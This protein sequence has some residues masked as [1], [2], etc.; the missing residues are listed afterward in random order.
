MAYQAEILADSISE[1]GDRLTTFEVTFPRLILAEFN[2]PRMFSR[3]SAS[4]RAIPVEK[5][6]I[7]V[8]DE[9]FIPAYWGVNQPGMQAGAELGPE[10]Q[11][12]ATGDWLL[13][14]DYAVLGAV[15]LIG[16][17]EKLK[18]ETLRERID[19]IQERLHYPGKALKTPLHK[20]I[21]NREL[22]PYMWHTDIITATELSNF[23]ALRANPQA[24]PAFQPIAYM[25]KDLYET[26]EPTL[27]HE[28]EWH[29]PLVHV[30]ERHLSLDTLKKVSTGRCARVSYL[31]HDTGV[32]DVAKDVGLHD[33][34]RHNGHMSPFEHPARPMTAEEREKYMVWV[35]D[36]LRLP[37]LGN[38]RGWVQYRKEIPHEH[39][40]ALLESN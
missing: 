27:L 5:Q 33:D 35:N 29:L 9:P 25:M 8:L 6:L 22:E 7:R 30:D 19:A 10:E 1:H 37:F 11:E 26:H 36:E 15:A 20:Q 18:D 16:G 14:R 24:E 4:S 38:F 13:S 23:F 40:F 12:I 3:N 34:L 31:T 17:T 21:A 28:G 32:R 2:T 39:D